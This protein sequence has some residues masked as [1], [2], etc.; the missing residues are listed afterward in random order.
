VDDRF[1]LDVCRRQYAAFYAMFRQ[2]VLQCPAGYWS[3]CGGEPPFWQQVYHTLWWSDFYLSESPQAFRQPSFMGENV[4]DLALAP[5]A[6][7]S[8][9]QLLAYL[10][11]VVAKGAALMECLEAGGLDAQNPFYWTGPTVGH[12]LFYN[13]R[14]AQ[15]HLG[16]LDSYLHRASAPPMGWLCD[17]EP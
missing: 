15:H 17:Q 5:E 1:F 3:V 8:R 9:E 13:L 16:W 2:R 11:A 14:H 6:A 12:R 10:D 7:P 4:Q